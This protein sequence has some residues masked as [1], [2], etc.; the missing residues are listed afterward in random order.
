MENEV[1]IPGFTHAGAFLRQMLL[2]RK[3][4]QK[5]LAKEVKVHPTILNQI[6]SG[7]R[8]ISVRIAVKLEE[9]LGVKAENW[10]KLQYQY[11]INKLRKKAKKSGS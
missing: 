5:D 2:D 8:G 11:E 9:A 1:L 10:M 3:R 6:I 7:K 4:T